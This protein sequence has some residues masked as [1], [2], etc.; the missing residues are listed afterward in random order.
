[1]RYTK[2]TTEILEQLGAKPTNKSCQY[3]I[4]SI[5]Y[6]NRLDKYVIPDSEMVMQR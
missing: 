6:I 5:E 3:I 1:M 2:Y 4:S